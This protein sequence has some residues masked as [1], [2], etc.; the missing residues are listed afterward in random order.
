VA[1]ELVLGGPEPLP[2]LL[3]GVLRGAAGGLPVGHE[4]LEPV[5]GLGPLGGLG[6]ALGFGDQLLLVR[7][8]LLALSVEAGE[9]AA[10]APA[11]GV[12]RGGVTLPQLA[13]GLAVDALDRLPLVEDLPHPVAGNLPLGA[14][15]RD[16]LGLG[17]QLALALGGLLPGQRAS[18]LLLLRL[19]GDHNCEL[20]KARGNGVKVADGVDLGQRLLQPNHGRLRVLRVSGAAREPGLQQFDL[21]DQVV[22]AAGEV[23]EALLGRASLP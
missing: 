15:G 9:V 18:G 6:Q 20:L 17:D 21:G 23:R 3:L 5:R 14:L 2:E 12:P 10:T 4:L 1:E 11:E 7:L 22:V 19:G 16:Q 8:R 13:V